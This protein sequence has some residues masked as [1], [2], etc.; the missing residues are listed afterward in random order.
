MKD[1]HSDKSSG[2]KRQSSDSIPL[3]E[4]LENA[5]VYTLR[6]FL[7]NETKR[8]K[9]LAIRLKTRLI[10][11]ATLP[12][13]KNK[14]QTLV[15]E[16]IREDVHGVVLLPKREVKLLHETIRSLLKTAEELIV[17]KG[18]RE[19]YKIIFGIL[20][21]LH[22][23]LDKTHDE[24]P[25]LQEVQVTTYQKLQNLLLLD[26]APEL[27]DDIH[28]DAFMLLSKSYHRL[29]DIQLNA[30]N[31]ILANQPSPEAFAR[32]FTIAKHR[33]TESGSNFNWIAWY[34]ILCELNDTS[35]D[36]VL[37]LQVLEPPDVVRVARALFENEFTTAGYS[38]VKAFD[39]R[40][41]IAANQS[42]NWKKWLFE[43]SS[44]KGHT[45]H[46]LNTGVE[47][48]LETSDYSYLDKMKDVVEPE[49][50]ASALADEQAFDVLAR[51]YIRQEE[52]QKLRTIID[53][54]KDIGLIAQNASAVLEN[55]EDPETFLRQQVHQFLTHRAGVNCSEELN[56][57]IMALESAGYHALLKAVRDEIF[58]TFPGRFI[59]T[60]E[61]LDISY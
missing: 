61:G 46:M 30:I 48:I 25:F 49:M 3:R 18:Y 12:G 51:L 41:D 26:L 14:Y 57:L 21:N 20:V 9:Q 16:I 10:E 33:L 28:D 7:R 54:S 50:I 4:L 23:Y 27:R 36:I 40:V 43:A 24:A 22:R 47:L 53:Q 15:A 32:L 56:N 5:D 19:T 45:G 38:W 8:N 58:T 13:L 2:S 42:A 29:P 55:T 35:P 1:P 17:T 59:E 11:S 39:G 31:V 52:W 37:L 60:T 34:A 6:N 44:D